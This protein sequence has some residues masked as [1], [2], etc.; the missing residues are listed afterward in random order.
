MERRDGQPRW[1]HLSLLEDVELGKAQSRR[2][3]ANEVWYPVVDWLWISAERTTAAEKSVE[4]GGNPFVGSTE[5]V[6]RTEWG[7]WR[8]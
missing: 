8:G 5:G 1:K 3:R 2:I 4:T 7:S 6:T